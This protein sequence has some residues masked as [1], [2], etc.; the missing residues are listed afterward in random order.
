[1]IEIPV[2]LGERRYTIA[3]GYGLARVLPDLLGSEHRSRRMALVSGRRIFALHGSRVARALGA[4]GTVRPV[5][6]PDG[7]R[8][9]NRKTLDAV[10]ESFLAAGLGRDG[11][12][13]ALGGG[14][15]GDVAG[16]AAATYMRGIDWVTVPTTLLS[17]VDSSI[18]GKVG[19][20]HPGAKNLIGAI[21]QPKAVVIDPTFLDT[22]PLREARSGV[23]EILKAGIL[24][25]RALFASLRG[26]PP[27]LRG[28]SRVD[29]E[30]AVAGACR[31]K[32]EVVEK[33]E[34]EGGL[35]M[36]LNLG[37]TLGHALEAVTSYRRFTHGEAVGWGMIGAAWIAR[38]RG[39]LAETAFDAIASAVDGLGPRP[40][41]SDLPVAALLE[42]L[43]R[44]KKAR[45]G[46]AVFILPTAIG[47]VVVKG[48]VEHGE[49]KHALK[50]LAAREVLLDRSGG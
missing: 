14:V 1:M 4:L 12:V 43:T 26:A 35:R 10:Y 45:D 29:I 2:E 32:A 36:V 20:N 9:K 42:A 37:H 16:F 22:L 25:D 8:F 40:R 23:Y 6:I 44:D 18:G 13:V 31:V 46:R 7:E 11:L 17:M 5:L 27:G 21:H 30:R 47:R 19:I 50:V 15:V 48:D 33:D 3:I 38:R 41:V 49:I 28:W 39:L 34:R 24:A